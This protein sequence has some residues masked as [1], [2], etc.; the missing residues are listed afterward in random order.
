MGNYEPH[1]LNFSLLV[2]HSE[3]GIDARPVGLLKN[4]STFLVEKLVVKISFRKPKLREDND[5]KTSLNLLEPELF[6]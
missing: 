1:I 3:G 6:L 4:V 5:M 2:R